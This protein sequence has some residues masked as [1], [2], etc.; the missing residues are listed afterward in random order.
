MRAAIDT[1]RRS[2]WALRAL[3]IACGAWL[4]ASLVVP[5]LP[6]WETI[7]LYTIIFSVFYVGELWPAIAIWALLPVVAI[8]VAL[9]QLATG[10]HRSAG[11]WLL[12]PVAGLLIFFYGG[13]VS[14]FARFRLTKGAYDRV[15]SDARA[16]HCDA[17]DLNHRGAGTDELD[18]RA[19]VIVV[20]P[21][22][23]FGSIWHGVVYDASDEI[24]KQPRHRSAVWNATP[25][26]KHLACSGVN[27]AL[28]DHYYRASGDYGC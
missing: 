3:G 6:V 2:E 22:G 13:E 17:A 18:C 1:R 8:A 26:G 15:I 19:P 21:W 7:S 25:I 24:A 28:G 12:V 16:G 11:A 14:D 10:R 9:K 20:F 5:A 23:G 4:I 27:F